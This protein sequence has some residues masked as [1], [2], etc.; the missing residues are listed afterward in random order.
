M[1][2]V[3]I[4]KKA[5]T[6]ADI[7]RIENKFLE[8]DEAKLLLQELYRRPSTYRIARLAELMYLTGVRFWRRCHPN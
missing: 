5:K 4:V 2:N 1:D 6:L 7:Q 8:H 3:T